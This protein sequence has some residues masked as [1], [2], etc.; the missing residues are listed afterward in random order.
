MQAQLGL[1]H[2]G[3]HLK[4]V[5]KKP[6]RCFDEQACLDYVQM[7]DDS[8][9]EDEFEA[10]PRSVN[11]RENRLVSRTFAR[12]STA[13]SEK[14]ATHMIEVDEEVLELLGRLP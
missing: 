1:V 11:R 2:N 13:A 3:K 4:V 7:S 14:R 5:S 12:Q 6:I 10:R 8:E 9:A